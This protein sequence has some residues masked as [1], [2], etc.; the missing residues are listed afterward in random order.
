MPD[1]RSSRPPE[2]WHS[3]LCALDERLEEP[4]SLVC[5]GGFVLVTVYHLPRVTSGIDSI[6]SVT[7]PN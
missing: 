6:S 3:F 7:P 4:T 1:D 2:P 5:L